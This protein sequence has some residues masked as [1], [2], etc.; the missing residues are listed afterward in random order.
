MKIFIIED[1]DAIRDAIKSYL[2]LEDMTVFEFS[3]ITEAERKFPAVNPDLMIL[4]V[5]LPDGDGFRFAK[6]IRTK[7]DVPIIFLTARTEESD[8]ITGLEIGADDYII[9]PFS[10]KEL[11]LRV[12]AVLKRSTALSEKKSDINEYKLGKSKMLIDSNAHRI[13]ENGREIELT[14]AEWKIISFLSEKNPQ[15]FNRIQ[16]LEYCLDSVA[17]GSERTVDTHIKNIRHKLEN[18]NW[19]STVRGF[20]Y[21]FEG[22]KS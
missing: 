10:T 12:K 15:V 19:L 21:R 17:E 7:S 2:E 8:R 9:K 22:S 14:Q 13:Y 3:G 20:G 4:D 16:L 11:V 6:R 18:K 5:M 1:N